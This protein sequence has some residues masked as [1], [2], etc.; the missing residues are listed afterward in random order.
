MMKVLDRLER[1]F[2]WLAV[3]NI[4]ILL[5]TL[6]ALGFLMI[7][8]EPAWSYR[9]ALDP[10]AV[11]SGGEYWR[12]ITFLALPL[13]QSPIW[14]FFV[15]WFLYFILNIIETRWGAFKTT[16]Y[17]LTAIVFSIAYS[18]AFQYPILS[19]GEF[20]STLFFAA[21]ALFPNLEVQLFFVL[22]VKLKWLAALSAILVLR[23]FYQS[24]WLGRFYLLVIYGNF[25]LFFSPIV[26]ERVKAAMRKRK[27]QKN[28]R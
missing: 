11:A 13:T 6:Q 19:A 18:F 9:L 14:M 16:L 15:L 27:F 26:M 10:V 25:I 1:K 23:E 8:V 17:V 5:I 4:A 12:L 24:D 22:P 21:A 20:Q 28:F 7:S 3:P 2:G